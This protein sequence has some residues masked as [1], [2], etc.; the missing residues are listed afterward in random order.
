MEASTRC[1]VAKTSFK[2]EWLPS[3]S[4]LSRLT[5][6]RRWSGEGSEARLK[7]DTRASTSA[8]F[9]SSMAIDLGDEGAARTASL[10]A[11]PP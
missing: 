9:S 8:L 1:I 5:I 11:A 10:P 6:R 2:A 7:R 4:A 3:S